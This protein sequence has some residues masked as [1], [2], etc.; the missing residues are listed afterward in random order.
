MNQAQQSK[1]REEAES[2]PR[3]SPSWT[4]QDGRE[5]RE[6]SYWNGSGWQTFLQMRVSGGNWQG[7]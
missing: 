6:V 2:A 7:W 3:Y 4:G 1:A 5:W